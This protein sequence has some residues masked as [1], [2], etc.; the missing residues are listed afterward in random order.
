MDVVR[1]ILEEAGVEFIP[2]GVRR[3]MDIAAQTD[4]RTAQMLCQ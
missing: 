1:R 3:R 2:Q 4:L